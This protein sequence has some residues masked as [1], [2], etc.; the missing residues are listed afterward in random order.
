MFQFLWHFLSITAR[1]IALSLFASVYPLWIGPVCAAHWL[2][3]TSWLVFQR[4]QAC[5]TRCEE[6]L[7]CLVLGA[8]YIFSFFNAKEERTR[9]KYLIYYS[10]CFVE[11]T[12]LIIVWFLFSKHGTGHGELYWYYYPGIVGHYL[13]FFGGV[14]FMVRLVYHQLS[15]V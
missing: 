2:I 4:T 1:V 6:I 5:Q 3:M 10:F 7:F 15:L 9:Y 14:L 11:N 12:A 13:A 8:I